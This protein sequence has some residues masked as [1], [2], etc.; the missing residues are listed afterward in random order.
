M[1]IGGSL[2][3]IA[4][5]AVLKWAVTYRTSHVNID[6]VGT[7]LFIVGLVGLA[8]SLALT[9]TRRRT[10]VVRERSVVGAPDGTGRVV[11]RAT[12]VEPTNI[13]SDL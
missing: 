7:I 9:A 1:R 13:D 5:G 4:V 6:T 10:D 2:I 11:S 12:Y 3:L 8:L